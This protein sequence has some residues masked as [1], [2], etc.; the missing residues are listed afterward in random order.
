LALFKGTTQ[1]IGYV[2]VNEFVGSF[3]IAVLV[4]SVLDA[5]NGKLLPSRKVYMRSVSDVPFLPVFA[6]PVSAPF[7]LGAAYF[8]IIT[9]F[10]L[11][12]TAVCDSL[13]KIY[14]KVLT[15]YPHSSTLP[16]TLAVA[17]L[18]ESSGAV[19]LSQPTTLLWPL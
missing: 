4:F 16:V 10:S 17:L 11:Q 13:R 9:A 7:M 6:S 2:F 3:V 8:V 12:S 1:S 15:R 5:S 14:T 18:Q 19:A